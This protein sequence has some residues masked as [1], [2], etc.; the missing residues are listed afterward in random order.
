MAQQGL[1][2]SDR[3]ED[4]AT[5]PCSAGC[6][7][8]H[9][10]PRRGERTMS[11][12]VETLSPISVCPGKGVF[13]RAVPVFASISKPGEYGPT[14]ADH[15]VDMFFSSSRNGWSCVVRLLQ[16]HPPLSPHATRHGTRFRVISADR[17]AQAW[18]TSKGEAPV[19][20]VSTLPW[21]LSL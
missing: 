12:T 19:K 13:L 10:V 7:W 3:S 8:S 6:W 21:P 2:A 18:L 20:W 5:S 9:K 1:S 16:E 4:P 14:R 15:G 11:L 17:L